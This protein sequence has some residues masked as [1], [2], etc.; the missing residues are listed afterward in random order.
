MGRR[1]TPMDTMFLYGE[2]GSSM[3]HVA[4][5]LMLTP[6]EGAPASYARDLVTDYRAAETVEQPWNLRL[7]HPRLKYHPANTWVPTDEVDLDYHV[8]RWALPSPADER[9]LGILISRLHSQP[10]DFEKPP[11]ETHVV[12][13]LADGRIAVYTK[14]HHSLIDGVSGL[15]LLERSLADSPD[16]EKPP[17]FAQKLDGRARPTASSEGGR[18]PGVRSVAGFAAREV[19][20]AAK[21]TK[22][23]VDVNLR[24]RGKREHLVGSVQAP[25]TL[26]NG[27]VSRNRRFAKQDYDLDRL[28]ALSKKY[29]A[30][31][32]DVVLAMVGGGLRR[33]LAELAE[34]PQRPLI[35]FMPVSVHSKDDTKVGNATGA[36]LASLATDVADPVERLQT[37][38]ASTRAAKAQLQ[39]MPQE[40]ALAYS[41]A[42]LAPHLLLA[43]AVLTRIPDPLP[44]TFNV[45]ISNI[46]GPRETLYQR[47]A[48]VD[49]TYPVSIPTHGMALNITLHSYDQKLFFG[50]VGC[51]ETVPGLQKLAVYTGQALDELEQA[52]ALAS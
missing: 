29:D 49:A 8:R 32:N 12:E 52:A 16:Q 46:P 23:L 48:R 50:F 33:Y 1:L 42:L 45:C 17:F 11:W 41:A 22:A 24:R 31:V 6:P 25:H 38:V 14:V 2:T 36:V 30:T 19:T 39:G 35:A 40:A 26:L 9:Q 21:L 47:G 34:L 15:G 7:K 10:L 28:K 51:P 5:L 18:L 4:S 37:V 27:P 13:G 43:G 3:M 44:F 20:A